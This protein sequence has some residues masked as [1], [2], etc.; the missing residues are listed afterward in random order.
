MASP[1]KLN[2]FLA[3]T[4]RR[5]D[6]FHDLVSLAAP[7]EWG[8]RLGV[9]V[10]EGDFS[11]ECDDPAVPLDGT[12]LILRAARAFREETGLAAGAAF[13]LEKR[14]P[15]GAGLGGGSSNAVAALLALNR[16]AGAPLDT[17]R[18]EAVAARLGSDCP[19]FLRQGPVVI[20]GRGERVEPAGPGV[21]AR[22]SGRR[23]ILFKPGFGIGTAWAYGRL[24]RGGYGPAGAAESRLAA[25]LASAAAP[26]EEILSNDFERIAFLKFPAIDL[27]L[28]RL[29]AEFR[30]DPCLSGSGSAC[31]A[32]LPDGHP[33]PADGVAAAVREV[34]G[35]SSTVVETRFA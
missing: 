1:A 18:L 8:D 26:A 3:V 9:G 6:G 13:V 29:R 35:P 28:G 20:R 10:A 33:E 22:I 31:F 16:L 2:L 19:M 24:A 4:G 21:S 27:L 5:P 25:W 30:L 14:I 11:L 32:L 7:V 12:N 34:W 15:M 17:A 23:V